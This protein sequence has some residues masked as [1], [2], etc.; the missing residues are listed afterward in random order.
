MIDRMLCI[1][2]I[3]IVTISGKLP[4]R[5][6]ERFTKK[7]CP[8]ITTEFNERGIGQFRSTIFVRYYEK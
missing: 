3:D 4:C 8:C 6:V 1:M 7:K 2:K 5:S